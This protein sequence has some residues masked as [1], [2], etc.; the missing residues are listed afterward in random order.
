MI[1]AE[2]GEED[3]WLLAGVLDVV[4]HVA[5]NVADVT[6]LVVEGARLTA[7]GEDRHAALAREV[8][9]P[10]VGVRVPV[11]LADSAR[12]NFDSRSSDCLR[13]GE[14]ARVGD[15]YRAAARPG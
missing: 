1:G 6:R 3:K 8:V 13:D 4:A 14:I 11:K 7:R 12:F 15:A 9:L 10:L 2:Q 5:R